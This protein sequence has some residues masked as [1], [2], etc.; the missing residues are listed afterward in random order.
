MYLLSTK[1]DVEA[2]SNTITYPKTLNQSDGK[3]TKAGLDDF[4]DLIVSERETDNLDKVRNNKRLAAVLSFPVPSRGLKEV[5]LSTPSKKGALNGPFKLKDLINEVQI[6]KDA[7][8]EIEMILLQKSLE[9][10]RMKEDISLLKNQLEAEEQLRVQA[11]MKS[12]LMQKELEK[13]HRVNSEH[14][15]ER[16]DLKQRIKQIRRE[17]ELIDAS[18]SDDSIS[19]VQKVITEIQADHSRTKEEVSNLRETNKKLTQRIAHERQRRDQLLR[20][21]TDYKLQL[22][23]LTPKIAT[24]DSE[25]SQESEDIFNSDKGIHRGLSTGSLD[26]NLESK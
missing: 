24:D 6:K 7:I 25:E 11:E 15:I 18:D 21:F 26:S 14:N 1:E 12:S 8:R 20:E 13:L 19:K 4:V 3:D 17:I 23:E 5:F 10:N 9:K 22:A 16:E 2:V